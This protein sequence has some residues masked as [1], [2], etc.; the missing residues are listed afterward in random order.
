MKMFRE[1]TFRFTPTDLIWVRRIMPGHM[2]HVSYFLCQSDASAT[3]GCD[4]DPGDAALTGHFRSSQEQQ[5][6]LGPERSDLVRDIITYDDDLT[7]GRTLGCPQGHPPSHHSDLKRQK[8]G[9]FI[10]KNKGQIL[11]ENKGCNFEGRIRR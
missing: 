11:S 7:S 3:V 10:I 6:L 1:M 9:T 5:V 4:V 8:R 2:E